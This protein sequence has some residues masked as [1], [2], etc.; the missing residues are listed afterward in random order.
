ME[1]YI[2]PLPQRQARTA[3]LKADKKPPVDNKLLQKKRSSATP[4]TKDSDSDR[5]RGQ[6]QNSDRVE[7]QMDKFDARDESLDQQLMDYMGNNESSE[8][9]FA[10]PTRPPL[11]NTMKPK[12]SRQNSVDR[13]PAKLE[14]P[15]LV[16]Q[17]ANPKRQKSSTTNDSFSTTQKKTDKG[18]PPRQAART[19]PVPDS[20]F[21]KKVKPEELEEK[22]PKP[23]RHIQEET[24]GDHFIKPDFN[25]SDDQIE[26]LTEGAILNDSDEHIEQ[27]K[28]GRS[29]PLPPTTD[30]GNKRPIAK[31]PDPPKPVG[32]PNAQNGPKKEPPVKPA[33]PQKARPAPAPRQQSTGK[34]APRDASAD[35]KKKAVQKKPP[36]ANQKD[37]RPPP[38]TRA[39]PK[40]EPKK[41][42][43]Q[44]LNR[45]VDEFGENEFD[46]DFEAQGHDAALENEFEDYFD[47]EFESSGDPVVRKQQNFMA[48]ATKA[49]PKCS[50]PI[51]KAPEKASPTK[52]LKIE[53]KTKIQNKEKMN[54][55]KAKIEEKVKPEG[56][57]E[58]NS[59]GSKIK[60]TVKQTLKEASQSSQLRKSM[61]QD[62]MRESYSKNNQATESLL[63]KSMRID[64]ANTK[65]NP[66]V[67]NLIKILN[68]AIAYNSDEDR[69]GG[70]DMRY[71]DIKKDVYRSFD[72][73]MMTSTIL[74]IDLDELCYCY[75]HVV[76]RHL[77]NFAA[78]EEI[79]QQATSADE[80]W[81]SSM[82]QYERK[83]GQKMASDN[84]E[85]GPEHSEDKYDDGVKLEESNLVTQS[86][87]LSKNNSVELD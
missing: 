20:Q 86:I 23:K 10:P 16:A 64:P 67:P 73:V 61:T 47:N 75:G 9:F 79:G 85:S 5:Y 8:D 78:M 57:K 71:R 33:G 25:T 4:V 49:D 40:V 50:Q 83:L 70:L 76:L 58:S 31:K 48:P 15:N 11:A 59:K 82:D 45:E 17:T 56:L 30:L 65:E 51:K 24:S 41:Y 81:E 29:K 35:T 7:S 2:P 26:D 60:G 6:A 13:K 66:V 52:E 84:D 37:K 27:P 54:T 87:N 68:K 39:K 14:K 72:G 53:D 62:M 38:Q 22:H 36:T 28:A 21:K 18:Q 69:G 1:V 32:K 55:D 46:E 77:Q 44:E 63:Q 74:N 80:E 42:Q 43:S 3:P 19:M 34:A 12:G